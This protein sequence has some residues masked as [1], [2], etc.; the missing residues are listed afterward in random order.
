MLK[1]GIIIGSTRPGRNGEAV[2]QW[3]YEK[4][5]QR[6]DAEY[7]IVDLADYNLPLLDEPMPASL[8]QYSKEHT[9]KWAEKIDSLDGFI[10][11]TAEYNHAPTGALKNA[12]DYLHHE[13]HNKAI[14]F[15]AY[16]SSLGARAVE[17]LRLI[18]AELQAP[19][20]RAQVGLSV[21]TDFDFA[22]G[23]FTPQEEIHEPNMNAMFE[24]LLAW[25]SA[26]KPLRNK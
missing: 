7:E 16:G 6:N 26:L 24:Q 21:F 11:V 12:I 20:V 14:G 10:V 9:K 19:G 5:K 25:S 22:K 4:A 13:W 23:K 18:F 1:I 2:A 15:V 8:G 3:V 17:H